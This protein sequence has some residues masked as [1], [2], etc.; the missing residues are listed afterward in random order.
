M[1]H[2]YMPLP[3]SGTALLTSGEDGQVKIWSKAGMLRSTLASTVNPVYA[4]AWGAESNAVLFCSGRDLNVVPLQSG[5]K[6]LAWQ[7]HDATILRVD[8]S[9]V[10]DLIVSGGEDF[11][12]KVSH[13]S[14][15]V[16]NKY[17]P[18]TRTM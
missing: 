11:R 16:H 14:C 17:C 3:A 7:G 18:S 9:L 10:N 4:A 13:A 6:K 8:W 1:Q 2:F 5:T 12:Y 15:K